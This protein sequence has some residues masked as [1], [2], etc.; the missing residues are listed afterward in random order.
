MTKL[1]R[2]YQENEAIILG[3]GFILLVLSAWEIVPSVTTPPRGLALFFVTPS[4]IALTFLDL[5]AKGELQGHLYVST[6]EFLAGLVIA[7]VVGLSL[8]TAVGRSPA[9]NALLDPFITAFNAT[10]RLVFVPLIQLWMGIGMWPVTV[11]VFIGALFPLLINTSEG[12]KNVDRVLVNVVR[13]FGANE[14]QIMKMVV[15]PNSLPY[16]IA[17]LRLAVGRAILGVVVGEIFGASKG[18]GAMIAMAAGS[19]SSNVV[20]VGVVLFM[21][22]S[23]ILTMAVKVV[24]SRLS[25]WRPEA[26]KTF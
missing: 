10:P 16:V 19:Y 9:V 24:E 5:V 23:L 8:G 11:I 25:R 26:V 2:I 18:L 3:S 17:G 22:I 14:W 4:K 15:L 20:F 13:S 12:V 21:A 6:V 7:V 1:R